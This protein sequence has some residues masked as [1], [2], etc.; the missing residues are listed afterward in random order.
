MK[1]EGFLNICPWKY[2]NDFSVI[3]NIFSLSWHFLGKGYNERKESIKASPAL[4]CF[5]TLGPGFH[6]NKTDILSH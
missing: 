4:L 2:Q 3:L 5:Y 1:L 6:G